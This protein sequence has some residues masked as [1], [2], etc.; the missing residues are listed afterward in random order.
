MDDGLPA[1]P[2]P[3]ATPPCMSPC[4]PEHS[5]LTVRSFSLPTL[6][7]HAGPSHLHRPHMVSRP[8]SHRPTS[9]STIRFPSPPPCSNPTTSASRFCSAWNTRASHSKYSGFRGC[10]QREQSLNG[11]Y[12]MSVCASIFVKKIPFQSRFII[13]KRFLYSILT[14]NIISSYITTGI[15]G[16]NTWIPHV[17]CPQY[18]ICFSI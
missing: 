1:F 4:R 14:L 5:W 11:C 17:K 10:E 12:S 9:P 8:P 16:H 7:P 3:Y 15:W 18:Y 2:C 13:P 6:C